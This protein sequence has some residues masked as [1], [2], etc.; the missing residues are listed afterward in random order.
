[1]EEKQRPQSVQETK[2]EEKIVCVFSSEHV[3]ETKGEP[4]EPVISRGPGSCF[5]L[6]TRA[7]G[8]ACTVKLADCFD[9]K[10]RRFP[11]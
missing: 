4:S 10:K 5:W 3:A 8:K 2:R 11:L 7:R 9:L 1:M 6:V